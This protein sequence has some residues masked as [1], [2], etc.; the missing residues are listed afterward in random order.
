MARPKVQ[1][2]K[3]GHDTSICGRDSRNA[4]NECKRQWTLKNKEYFSEYHLE[5]QDAQLERMKEYRAENKDILAVK[6]KE[7]WDAHRDQKHEMDRVYYVNN[8]EKCVAY[9]IRNQT[10][11]NLREVA[12]TDWDNV[13]LVYKNQPSNTEVD[14]YIPLQGDD[15]AGLH[16]SWNLQYLTPSQ[17]ASKG[18]KCNLLEASEWYGKI[19]VE[20]GLK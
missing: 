17:N 15:V 6:E 7:F 4:C 20:A 18:N 11:R 2:C 16:V 8:R 5:H 3:H 12:W 9:N 19:L 1:F 10:N 14:H 13:E